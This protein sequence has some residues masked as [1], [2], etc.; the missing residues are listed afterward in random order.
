MRYEEFV[1]RVEEIK[2]ELAKVFQV[3][4]D[5]LPL[6]MM[7]GSIHHSLSMYCK[8]ERLRLNPMEDGTWA[9]TMFGAGTVMVGLDGVVSGVRGLIEQRHRHFYDEMKQYAED[10]ECAQAE[11]S[12]LERQFDTSK[13]SVEALASLLGGG[14]S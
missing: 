4:V 6:E 3:G 14:E 12:H 1:R 8:Y 13:R 10:L 11:A 2:P 9:L 7:R 5:D